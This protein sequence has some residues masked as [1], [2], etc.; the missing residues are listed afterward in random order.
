M[1]RC[2]AFEHLRLPAACSTEDDDDDELWEEKMRRLDTRLADLPGGG[3]G[4][5]AIVYVS[6]VYLDT[7]GESAALP[8]VDAC[9]GACASPKRWRAWSPPRLTRR[10]RDHYFA[11]RQR[12]V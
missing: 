4:D 1:T 3:L 9:V 12:R 11:S 10:L 2:C 7:L 8:C 6:D 5:G